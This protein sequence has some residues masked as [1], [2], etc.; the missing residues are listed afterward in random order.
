[1]T[2][3]VFDFQPHQLKQS[4]GSKFPS[5]AQLFC[6]RTRAR[7]I[8]GGGE[9]VAHARVC[10]CV[11]PLSPRRVERLARVYSQAN[12]H[13]RTHARARIQRH[14]IWR[15]STRRGV[16]MR[17]YAPPLVRGVLCAPTTHTHATARVWR[18]LCWGPNEGRQASKLGRAGAARAAILLD[19]GWKTS[20]ALVTTTTTTTH[21]VDAVGDDILHRDVITQH[22]ADTYSPVSYSSFI[23]DSA[24]SEGYAIV[25][26]TCITLTREN[27]ERGARLCVCVC[28]CVYVCVYMCSVSVAHIARKACGI[29]MHRRIHSKGSIMSVNVMRVCMYV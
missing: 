12:S 10:V 11:R 29:C 27:G 24:L 13:A 8:D 20:R 16:C 2:R 14:S 22:A 6:A 21:H 17:A 23:V 18:S 28:A 4:E 25:A 1:M 3:S 19:S 5:H 9:N 7:A 15:A 26:C